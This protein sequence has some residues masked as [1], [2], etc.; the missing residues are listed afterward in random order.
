VSLFHPDRNKIINT[1]THTYSGVTQGKEVGGTIAPL[2]FLA[3]ENL[4][5]N[6]FLVEKILSKNAKFEAKNPPWG[7]L[8]A[9]LKF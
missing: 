1:H 7:K 9:K 8:R 6:L 3:V 4:S 2:K 5:E